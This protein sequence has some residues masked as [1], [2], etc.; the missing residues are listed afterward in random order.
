MTRVIRP[1]PL[2]Y[3]YVLLVPAIPIGLGIAT[4]VAG[5]SAEPPDWVTRL[6]AAASI[7]LLGLI[8]AAYVFGMS[9][10][11]TNSTVSKVFLFGLLRE[12]IPLARMGADIS[13]ER[14]TEHGFDIQYV[15]FASIDGR[16]AFTLL[17][18]WVWPGPDVDDLFVRALHVDTPMRRQNW[19]LAA[20]ALGLPLSGLGIVVA[21][22]VLF[23]THLIFQWPS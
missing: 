6:P 15:N 22:I 16:G 14:D 9:I 7:M 20:F 13:T 1:G 4:L 23:V 8:P 2:Q 18:G 3:A 21:A 19:I 17:R 5:F 12:T 11:L 10:E